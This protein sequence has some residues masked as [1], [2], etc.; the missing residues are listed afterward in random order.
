MRETSINQLCIRE[1]F[2]R[3]NRAT[4]HSI[5]N[6]VS[7]QDEDQTIKKVG[8]NSNNWAKEQSND[9]VLH[10]IITCLKEDGDVTEEL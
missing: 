9:R 8:H 6:D 5:C 3:H 4:S 1:I 2:P 7:D 10:L